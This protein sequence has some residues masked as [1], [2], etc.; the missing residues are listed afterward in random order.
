MADRA[1]AS[2][3]Q[4]YILSE[5]KNA[6]VAAQQTYVAYTEPS[7]VR[8]PIYQTFVLYSETSFAAVDT[9]LITPTWDPVTQKLSVLSSLSNTGSGV[10]EYG[11]LFSDINPT[12]LLM[13]NDGFVTNDVTNN[14]VISTPG[15]FRVTEN[16]GY[17]PIPNKKGLVTTKRSST[18]AV[19][20]N[21]S[22][23]VVGP[24]TLTCKAFVS[25]EANYDFL[26]IKLDGVV[27][28]SISGNT[29]A[30]HSWSVDI[31]AGVHTILLQ[32]VADVSLSFLDI[33]G[34][35]ELAFSN[36][37]FY[38]NKSTMG[39][40]NTTTDFTTE[41]E[42]TPKVTYYMRA[43][44]RTAAGIS[45]GDVISFTTGGGIGFGSLVNGIE[46]A[47]I[48]TGSSNVEAGSVSAVC[49]GSCQI[50]T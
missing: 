48:C 37:T 13:I 46:I 4:I 44:A 11:H 5:K 25:S 14:W 7:L 22:L 21:A 29:N 39:P 41:I 2:A 45:Y 31:P 8:I 19:D 17:S 43:Y 9:G 30:W 47:G 3:Q 16:Y 40:T 33:G 35:A 36:N 28:Y 18:G 12:P 34:I 27:K 10:I 20:G 23:S 50:N 32:Y 38:S 26:K 24:T 42:L 15:Y 6:I 1:I 49:A